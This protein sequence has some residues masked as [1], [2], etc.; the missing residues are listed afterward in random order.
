VPRAFFAIPM[1]LAVRD[2]LVACREAF[3]AQ[4]PDWAGEKWVAP[5]NLHITLR[6]LGSVPEP[7]CDHAVE[8]VGAILR[9]IE[10]FR[11]RLDV[12]RAI[13]QRRSASLLWVGPSEGGDETA[14]L[15][16]R[17]ATA[18]RFLDF[19]PDGRGFRTHVTLCRARRPRRVPQTAFDEIERVLHRADERSLTVSVR[20]VTL[21]ASTITPKG[22]VYTE[23]ARVPLGR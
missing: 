6:F 23:L 7:A 2:T 11:L 12:P 9:D 16:E 10:G 19:E 21:Y 17:I 14:T 13:P 1:P 5:E 4:D 8:R 15:A 20:Q 22:P 3:V 18:C